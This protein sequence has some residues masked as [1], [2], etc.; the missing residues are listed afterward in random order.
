[1]ALACAGYEKEVLAVHARLISLSLSVSLVINLL[2]FSCLI[3]GKL[4]S[5]VHHFTQID[6]FSKSKSEKMPTMVQLITAICLRV[7]STNLE[8]LGDLFKRD[9]FVIT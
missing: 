2:V 1:M 6:I 5:F 4:F 7:D 3:N 9:F 8:V